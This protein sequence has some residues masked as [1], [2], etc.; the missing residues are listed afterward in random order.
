MNSSECLC[1]L[2]RTLLC[3]V[4]SLPVRMS[5]RTDSEDR[6]AGQEPTISINFSCCQLNIKQYNKLIEYIYICVLLSALRVRVWPIL[7][8]VFHQSTATKLVCL[9]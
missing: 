1:A 3:C 2:I 4:S 7:Q 5:G 8:Q 9:P 6:F